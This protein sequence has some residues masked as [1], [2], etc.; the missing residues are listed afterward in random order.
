[1]SKL[2]MIV[3]RRPDIVV[4]EKKEKKVLLIDI[5]IP[6]DVRIEEKEEEIVTKYQCPAREVK[7]L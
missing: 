2:A 5:A 4:L 6:G 7:R 3:H 1:M